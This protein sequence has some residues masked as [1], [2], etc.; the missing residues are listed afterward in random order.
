[1]RITLTSLLSCGL[2]N[3]SVFSLTKNKTLPDMNG[4]FSSGCLVQEDYSRTRKT[5]FQNAQKIVVKDRR[6]NGYPEL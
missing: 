5:G 2:R 4:I 6:F 1:M 3:S